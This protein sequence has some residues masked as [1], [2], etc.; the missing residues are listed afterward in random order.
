M[1]RSIILIPFL[2]IFH[3]TAVYGDGPKRNRDQH[4][5][6]C[7]DDVKI[8]IESETLIFSCDYDQDL[9][10]E[11]TSESELY[12]SGKYIPLNR[13]QRKLVGEYYDQFML[14]L[15]QAKVIGKEGAKIGVEGAMIGIMAAKAAVLVILSDYELDDM[16][17]KIEEEAEELEERAGE[18]EQLADELEKQADDFEDLHYTMKKEIEELDELEWF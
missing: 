4:H 10:V 18:L 15:E 3:I 14:I 9:W 11:I 17:Q 7:L 2:L 12:I 16:E 6:R 5:F 13:Y 1:K 8:E